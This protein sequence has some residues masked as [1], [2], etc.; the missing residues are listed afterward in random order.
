M[1]E[2][3]GSMSIWATITFYQYITFGF[4]DPHLL[5]LVELT[6]NIEANQLTK[7]RSD[8][9]VMK[10]GLLLRDAASLVVRALQTEAA[11]GRAV[12]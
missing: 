3:V 12:C 7:S 8:S 2:T 6:L 10:L 9:V 4:I 11:T 1:S 5:D